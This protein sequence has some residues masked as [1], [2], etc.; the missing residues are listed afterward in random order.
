[1]EERFREL[2]AWYMLHK[3]LKRP[4]H[5]AALRTRY[6]DPRIEAEAP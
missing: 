5:V 4:M 1:M 6:D 3:A 2:V